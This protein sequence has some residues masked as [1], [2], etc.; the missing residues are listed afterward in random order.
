M[1]KGLSYGMVFVESASI[2]KIK[3][4]LTIVV[5]PVDILIKKGIQWKR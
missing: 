5:N 2:K 4:A 3:D 1:K